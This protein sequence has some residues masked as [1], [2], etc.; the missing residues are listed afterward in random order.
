V[1]HVQA[2]LYPSPPPPPPICLQVPDQGHQRSRGGGGRGRCWSSPASLAPT[3]F[4]H[5]SDP[6]NMPA[7]SVTF[8]GSPPISLERTPL[9]EPQSQRCPASQQRSLGGGGG[10]GLPRRGGEACKEGGGR[11]GKRMCYILNYLLSSDF[12]YYTPVIRRSLK[13]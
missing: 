13:D 9:S 6:S 4:S 7:P 5:S 11:A 1:D 2:K 8:D 3:E 12:N 10:E